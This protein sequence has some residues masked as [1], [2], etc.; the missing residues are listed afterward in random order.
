MQFGS[1]QTI[2]RPSIDFAIGELEQ[3]RLTGLG[4]IFYDKPSTALAHAHCEQQL[5]CHVTLIFST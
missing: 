5:V 2:D 1:E 3:A 4:Y